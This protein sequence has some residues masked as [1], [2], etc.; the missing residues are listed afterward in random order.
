[1]THKGY[2]ETKIGG[3]SLYKCCFCQVDS[4]SLDRLE[5]HMSRHIRPHLADDLPKFE[6]GEFPI[7]GKRVVISLLTWNNGPVAVEAAD[8]IDRELDILSSLGVH[9]KAVWVDNGS[10]NW[11][12]PEKLK[13]SWDLIRNE[14][15]LGQSHGRNQALDAAL[16]FNADYWIMIDGDIMMIP[17]SAHA[18]AWK[19][20]EMTSDFGCLGVYAYNCTHE[21]QDHD[22][23]KNCLIIPDAGID[24]YPSIAWTQYGCFRME[25]FLIEKLRF[26]EAGPFAGPGWGLE[27]D[28]LWMQMANA[29]YQSVNTKLFRYLH[30]RRQ[31]S[32][33]MMD[34]SLAAKL[35]EERKQFVLQ[36][37]GSSTNPLIMAR[38]HT[39][40][41][42]HLPELE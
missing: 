41:N 28:E 22:I 33:R 20:D 27:D 29:G 18:I 26:E 42:H 38:L 9:C 21:R 30:V 37:W 5:E 34:H 35:F 1:M 19:L 2:F 39:L 13:G 12:R 14:E 25:P 31:S 11:N 16:D 36:K 23:S 3:Q 15:N 32:V 8:A 6:H 17:Y 40:A 10:A 7:D 4:F 24:S